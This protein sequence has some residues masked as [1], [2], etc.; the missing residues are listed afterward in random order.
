MYM[1]FC[2][3]SYWR[4]Y[5]R[6]RPER[7]GPAAMVAVLIKYMQKRKNKERWSH[8]RPAINVSF[9]FQKRDLRKFTNYN[10]KYRRYRFL[11]EGIP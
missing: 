4:D 1:R 9:L 6:T 3:K 10:L 7:S 2:F 8:M 11:L 5:Y